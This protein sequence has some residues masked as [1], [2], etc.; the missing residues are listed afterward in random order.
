[1]TVDFE[2]LQLLPQIVQEIEIIKQ[3][4]DHSDSKRW[5]SVKELSHYLSYSKDTIYR[6]KEEQ[7]IENLHFYKRSG[8]ILFDRVAIDDWVI[9]KDRTND[10][11]QSKRRVVDNILSSI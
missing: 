1:M 8:K 9:G 4:L 2:N 3:R 5:L 7:F 10:T 6:L 11:N